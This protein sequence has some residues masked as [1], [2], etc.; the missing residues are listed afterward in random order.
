MV[1]RLL[2]PLQREKQPKPNRRRPYICRTPGTCPSPAPP[3]ALQTACTTWD[4]SAWN[5]STRDEHHGPAWDD[6]HGAAG[7]EQHGAARAEHYGS[8]PAG[9]TTGT[10]NRR[11]CE[12]ELFDEW[13]YAGRGRTRRWTTRRNG[14]CT[15]R[16]CD[17]WPAR[18][19]ST[20]DAERRRRWWWWTVRSATAW[21]V[22]RW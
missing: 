2:G 20:R 5:G 19:I 9:W 1:D 6:Q 8:A 15:R 13:D 7:D 12:A 4:G 11:E 18:R 21:N 17:G 14:R 10:S 16:W 3:A 22:R